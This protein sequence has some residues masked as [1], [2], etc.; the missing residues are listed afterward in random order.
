MSKRIIYIENGMVNIVQPI[1]KEQRAAETEDE[2]LARIAAKAVPQGIT[3]GVIDKSIIPTDRTFRNAWDFID[4]AIT[5]DMSKAREIHRA[6]VRRVRATRLAELDVQYQ[7]ADETGNAAEKA[8]IIA[9]KQTLRD[10]PAD[11]AIEAATTPEQ[12]KATWP[13]ILPDNPY[14]KR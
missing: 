13:L 2:F 9:K 4:Q 11:P 1:Y 12:L 3:S 7:R 6:H 10:L 5:V 14:I 8:L